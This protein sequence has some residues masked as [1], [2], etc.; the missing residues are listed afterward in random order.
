MKRVPPTLEGI[1]EAAEVIRNGGVVA[2]PTETVYGLAVNPFSLEAI[3]QLFVVKGR[4]ESN[5]VLLIAADLAQVE[6]VVG[7]MSDNARQCM[8]KYWPGPL[9]LVMPKRDI[10]PSELSGNGDKVCVPTECRP[11]IPLASGRHLNKKI[12]KKILCAYY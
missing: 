2:Y 5:P 9:S 3:Q 10:V 1:A 4:A 11:F 7:H 8:A 6:Q 12:K